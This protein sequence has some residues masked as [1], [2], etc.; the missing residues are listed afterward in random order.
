MYEN[1][2]QPKIPPPLIF[3]LCATV[4]LVAPKGWLFSLSMLIPFGILL[5]ALG[6]AAVS[7]WQFHQAKT[8]INPLKLDRTSCL[9]TKGIYAYS[10]NPMYLSLLLSLVALWFYSQNLNGIVGVLAFFYLINHWQIAAE[11]QALTRLFGEE[12]KS[13]QRKTGRWFSFRS[14][15]N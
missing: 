14:K 7:L 1:I 10:R 6:I 15:S 11:E 12:Y 2:K 4:I 5:M 13:Y 3:V 9:I 8:S